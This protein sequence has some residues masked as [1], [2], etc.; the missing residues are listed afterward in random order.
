MAI[1]TV[2]TIH[3]IEHIIHTKFTL[4]FEEKADH[5]V[6]RNLADLSTEIP[7]GSRQAAAKKLG[8]LRDSAA[9]PGLLTALQTDD[10]WMVRCAIIQ[11]LEKIADPRAIPVLLLVSQQ[12]NFQ[13]VRSYA[14]KAVERLSQ[15]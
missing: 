12:D 3:P 15:N 10:F 13:V 2:N 4:T 6:E 11:A 1:S 9:V 8:S 7:W 5:R 14:N